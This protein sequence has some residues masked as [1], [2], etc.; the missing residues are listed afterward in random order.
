M[1]KLRNWYRSDVRAAYAAG[2]NV[3]VLLGILTMIC[4]FVLFIPSM[5]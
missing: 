3:G 2:R 4:M 5:M 1:Q